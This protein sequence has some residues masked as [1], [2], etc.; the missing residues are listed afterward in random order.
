MPLLARYRSTIT[1]YHS[2]LTRYRKILLCISMHNLMSYRSY[3]ARSP[4][5]LAR[6]RSRVTR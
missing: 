4:Y 3:L 6:Y 2:K 5:Y 1:R